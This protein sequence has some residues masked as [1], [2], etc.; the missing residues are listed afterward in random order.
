MRVD[1]GVIP[2][3]SRIYFQDVFD[4]VLRLSEMVE[5]MRDLVNSTMATYLAITNTRLNEIMKVLA[6]I[7]TVFI[8]LGFLAAVFGMNFRYMPELNQ[9]WAY[10]TVWLI[11][12]AIGVAM[13]M[14]FRHRRW[15]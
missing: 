8:P 3:D 2:S 13:V 10:P 5:S 7:S 14:F 12:L 9:P 4:H 1:Y 15:L 6:M 11:F